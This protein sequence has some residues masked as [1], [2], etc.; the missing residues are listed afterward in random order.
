[1][2]R[3]DKTT[4]EAKFSREIL[5]MH[6]NATV[7]D[8]NRAARVYCRGVGLAGERREAALALVF[9]ALGKVDRRKRWRV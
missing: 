5:R 4:W 6:P 9:G 8:A 3:K 1:M 2:E 7:R